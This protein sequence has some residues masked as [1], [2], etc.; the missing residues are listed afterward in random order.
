VSFY[1]AR[2]NRRRLLRHVAATHLRGW[3]ITG[4]SRWATPFGGKDHFYRG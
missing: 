3:P 4:L 2:R 1:R